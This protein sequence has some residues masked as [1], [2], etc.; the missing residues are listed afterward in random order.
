MRRRNTAFLAL[1]LL[2]GGRSEAKVYCEGSVVEVTLAENHTHLELPASGTLE[3]E[4]NSVRLI[5]GDDV[6][7][8]GLEERR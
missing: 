4:N 2:S 5:L 3:W 7:T 8:L 6:V 1:L